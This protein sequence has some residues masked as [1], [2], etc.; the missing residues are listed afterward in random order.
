MT[1]L[2]ESVQVQATFIYPVQA[3]YNRAMNTASAVA[4]RLLPGKEDDTVVKTN[5]NKKLIV[6]KKL[7]FEIAQ[8]FVDVVAEYLPAL[9]KHAVELPNCCLVPDTDQLLLRELPYEIAVELEEELL[10]YKLRELNIEEIDKEVEELLT[11]NVEEDEE[12][13]EEPPVIEIVDD[14]YGAPSACIKVIALE[15]IEVEGEDVEFEVPVE[16]VRTTKVVTIETTATVRQRRDSKKHDYSCYVTVN[17]RV[18]KLPVRDV[19]RVVIEIPELGVKKELLVTVKQRRDVKKHDFGK[20]VTAQIRLGTNS[21]I[22]SMVGR[23]VRVL[24]HFLV[25]Q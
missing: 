13:S 8:K 23:S 11:D 20:Y 14:G 4:I 15:D 12:E 6:L 10:N 3:T 2:L 19:T 24:V 7:P 1:S 25:Q 22:R 18:T 16:V 5:T 9:M 21:K 17:V